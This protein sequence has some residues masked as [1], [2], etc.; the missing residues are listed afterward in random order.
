MSLESFTGAPAGETAIGTVDLRPLRGTCAFPPSSVDVCCCSKR[1][2]GVGLG[3]RESR[4]LI[5]HVLGIH[6]DLTSDFSGAL[7]GCEY[8][9]RIIR[10]VRERQGLFKRFSCRL[11]FR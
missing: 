11:L 9:R 8:L 3:Q 2:G 7:F 10:R 1:D 5:H 4:G 6:A